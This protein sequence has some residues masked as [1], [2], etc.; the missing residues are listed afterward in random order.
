MKDNDNLPTHIADD[1]VLGM[2]EKITNVVWNHRTDGR[3]SESDK[4]VRQRTVRINVGLV[5]LGPLD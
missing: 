5:G 1:F 4:K 3:V 2:G